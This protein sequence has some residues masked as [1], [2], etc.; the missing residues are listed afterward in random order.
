MVQVFGFFGG[1]FFGHT[2]SL[3]LLGLDISDLIFILLDYVGSLLNSLELG[4]SGFVFGLSGF[5]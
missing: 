1:R 4:F 3:S 2:G 5:V